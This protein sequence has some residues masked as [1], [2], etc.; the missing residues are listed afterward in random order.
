MAFLGLNLMVLFT[1][2]LSTIELYVKVKLVKYSQA[3]DATKKIEFIFQALAI[4]IFWLLLKSSLSLF[5]LEI[6]IILMKI[7]GE[8]NQFLIVVTAATVL[9]IT[10]I[11]FFLTGNVIAFLLV[12]FN[13]YYS[14]MTAVLKPMLQKALVKQFNLGLHQQM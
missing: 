1:L 5:G 11:A 6:T 2:V 14:G 7:M 3:E 13:C 9:L 10:F 12:A 4:L 8:K